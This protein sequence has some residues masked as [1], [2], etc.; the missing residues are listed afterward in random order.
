MGHQ[1][2]WQG[3]VKNM[4]LKWLETEEGREYLAD[5]L[6]TAFNRGWEEGRFAT[7]RYIAGYDAEPTEGNYDAND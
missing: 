3:D 1:E 2:E 6:D 7:A 4:A 5:A